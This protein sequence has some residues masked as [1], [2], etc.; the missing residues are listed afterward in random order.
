MLAHKRGTRP[1]YEILT[2]MFKASFGCRGRHA[3]GRTAPCRDFGGL[4]NPCYFPPL[5]L[6][7]F[8]FPPRPDPSC[9][10][11]LREERPIAAEVLGHA[12]LVTPV[13]G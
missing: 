1:R 3:H 8:G 2:L 13:V 5:T 10:G 9:C 11:V 6:L 7:L 4:I 12:M